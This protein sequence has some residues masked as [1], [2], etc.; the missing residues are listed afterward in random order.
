MV[1]NYE[2]SQGLWFLL[3]LVYSGCSEASLK[4][5]VLMIKRM[6]VVPRKKR[7]NES[8]KERTDLEEVMLQGRLSLQPK[9]RIY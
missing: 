3:L 7:N 6:G 2:S 5:S 1:L 8:R 4:I 9:A